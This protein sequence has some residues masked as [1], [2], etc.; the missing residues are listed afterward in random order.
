MSVHPGPPITTGVTAIATL[1]AD[2]IGS[3]RTCG[4]CRLEFPIGA[5]VHPMELRDWWACAP[6]TEA[7][8]PTRG[9]RSP[10]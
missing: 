9:H 10:T 1:S 7:L 2:L 5:D 6:C 3:T 4:R 8:L